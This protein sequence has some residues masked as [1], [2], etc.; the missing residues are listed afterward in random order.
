MGTFVPP[1]KNQAGK[2][3]KRNQSNLNDE[4]DPN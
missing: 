2:G 3:F 4:S 1:P